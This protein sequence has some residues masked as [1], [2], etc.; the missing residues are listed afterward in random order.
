MEETP[1]APFRKSSGQDLTGQSFDWTSNVHR[2]RI[3]DMRSAGICEQ[4]GVRRSVRGGG[5]FG[6]GYTCASAGGHLARLMVLA[7][8]A[9]LSSDLA[10]RAQTSDSQSDVAN[11][12]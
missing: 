8:G 3:I 10:L 6:D 1:A 4:D 7:I 12:S 9:Y 11:T 5:E 2:K